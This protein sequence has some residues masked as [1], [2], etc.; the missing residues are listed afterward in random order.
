MQAIHHNVTRAKKHGDSGRK[1]SRFTIAID[2]NDQ[3]GFARV[4]E[5]LADADTE[6]R[7]GLPEEPCDSIAVSRRG[8]ARTQWARPLVLHEEHWRAVRCRRRRRARW[9]G[10]RWFAPHQWFAERMAGHSRRHR[11]S[12][13][14]LRDDRCS[15]NR[16]AQDCDGWVYKHAR[17][18]ER[19]LNTSDLGV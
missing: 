8:P 5:A 2:V 17:G 11:R 15:S 19:L 14:L 13:R 1:A 9:W 3:G 12:P 7:R 4:M 6:R 16:H 10:R 18:A